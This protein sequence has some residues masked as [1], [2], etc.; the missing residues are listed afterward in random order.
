LG[1]A[2]EPTGE[3]VNSPPLR[4][5]IASAPGTNVSGSAPTN[6]NPPAGN[7]TWVVGFA[8]FEP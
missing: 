7:V 6:T 1:I 8:E 3:K 2:V 4:H 5:E